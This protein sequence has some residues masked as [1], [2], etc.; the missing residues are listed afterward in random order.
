MLKNI[1]YIEIN[2][3]KVMTSTWLVPL[4]APLFLI[5]LVLFRDRGFDYINAGDLIGG[6]I[7]SLVYGI[8]FW[9]PTILLILLTEWITIGKTA[10]KR[11]V[12]T[13]L[14]L[15]SIIAFITIWGIFGFSFR[16]DLELP[17]ALAFSIVI[18][19]LLRWLHL[20]RKERMFNAAVVKE[21]ID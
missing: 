4:A 8:I 3:Q 1:E 21:T 18:P 13:V 11:T 12:A 2:R 15:E 7:F 16:L 10:T 6:L 19:Q 20:N 17:F 14:T 5:F 9:F